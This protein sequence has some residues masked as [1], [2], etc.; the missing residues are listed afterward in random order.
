MQR[1]ELGLPKA[2]GPLSRRI[3]ERGSLEIQAYDRATLRGLSV[4]DFS[5]H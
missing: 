2:A 1:R 4:E 3:T 5:P